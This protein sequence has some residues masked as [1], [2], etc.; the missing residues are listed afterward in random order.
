MV[1]NCIVGCAL[2]LSIVESSH[3]KAFV[4]DLDPKY[5]L[6]SCSYLT[7]KLLPQKHAQILERV[8]SHLSTARKVALTIDIWTDRRMHSYLGITVHTFT[9]CFS[10]SGLLAFEQFKGSH[11]GTRIAAAVDTAITDNTLRG[12]VAFIVSDNASNMIK[13][14]TVL[15]ALTESQ[16]LQS[17]QSDSVNDNFTTHVDDPDLFSDLHEEELTE[18]NAILT[19]ICPVR[20]SCFAYSLQLVVKDGLT[21][22]TSAR[23]VMAKCCKLASLTHQSSSF[24]EEFENTFGK[25]RTIPDANATRWSSLFHQLSAVHNLDQTKLKQLLLS[26]SGQGHANLIY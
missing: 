4:H 23:P 10:K 11:T 8:Q 5:S 19:G 20:L 9:D 25:G 17:V 2:P 12:K 18:L 1:E 7:S 26:S 21:K 24:K 3:F 16:E 6:P 15:N 13:A 22:L 14:L